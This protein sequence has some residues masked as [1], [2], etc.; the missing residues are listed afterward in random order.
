LPFHRASKAVPFI[1]DN[2]E[3][4]QPTKP[5][6]IKFE[7]FI[8]DLLPHAE[9]GFVVEALASEAFAPVKNANGAATDTPEHSMQAISDLHRSWLEA[10]GVK[11]AKNVRVEINPRFAMDADELQARVKAGDE[12]TSDRY[13][14]I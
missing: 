11:V 13:F 10:A 14:N 5:N 7:R 3:L 2:G 12:I 1:D 6:A 9:H 4:I 8:F